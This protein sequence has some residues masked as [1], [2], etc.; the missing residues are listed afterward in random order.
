MSSVPVWDVERSLSSSF[1]SHPR[2]NM[3]VG[4]MREVGED[5][6]SGD[7]PEAE[8]EVQ[9]KLEP[10]LSLLWVPPS[11]SPTPVP[12]RV[13]HTPEYLTCHLSKQQLYS[14]G[15]QRRYLFLELYPT[16]CQKMSE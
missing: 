7:Y 10:C 11:P 8:A 13:P 1:T 14:S 9:G 16:I 5:N 15:E 12:G 6:T 3:G 2:A 4:G